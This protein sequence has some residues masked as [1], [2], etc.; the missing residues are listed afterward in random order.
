L[1][2]KEIELTDRALQAPSMEIEVNF[3][4]LDE[5]QEEKKV[6]AVGA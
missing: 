4:S 5:K 3:Q 6:L 1:Y 2:I